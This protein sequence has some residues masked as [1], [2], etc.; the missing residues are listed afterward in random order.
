[1][2]VTRDKT[3]NS[4]AFLTVE[5]EPAEVEDA[6]K[7]AYRR[8]VKK[9]NIPGFRKGKAPRAILE[10]YLG[11]ESLLEDALNSLVP[12]AYQKAIKE[13]EIEA[14]AQPQIEIA[15]TDPVVFTAVVPLRPTVALGDH[16]KIKETPEAVAVGESDVDAVIEQLR[17]QHA[18]WEPVER[19]VELGDLLVVD[20]ESSIDDKPFVSQKEAQLQV[21]QDQVFPAP[22]F[23]ERLLGMRAGE[24]REFRLEFPPDYPRA[25]LVGKEAA[26]KVRVTEVKQERLPELSDE[27][28]QGVNPEF[29]TLDG[30]REQVSTSL[31][32]RAEEKAR[33]DF[34]ERVITAAV[35]LARLEFPPVLVEA[36]V[37]RLLN[38]QLQRWQMGGLDEYL[39]SVNKT[40]EELRDGLRPLATER[41]TRSLVLGKI[42]EEEKIEVSDA[43]IDAEVESM[44]KG[45]TEN[46]EQVGKWLDTPQ[47]REAIR[48]SLMARKTIQRLVETANPSRE[49]EAQMPPAGD[50]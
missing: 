33:I 9:A 43:E 40:E 8:L 28:A 4:Q 39:S 35:D 25:E 49:E 16:S 30:L 31:R 13:Q 48:Q 22:K 29:K 37:D 7:K 11:K 14:I 38:Q 18:T 41:V 47:T 5:L 15:Q 2:K 44:L 20:V 3:E 21:L 23:G 32:L 19:P 24:E 10:G 6:L 26:F 27:F 42:A 12:E 45:T 1:M 34:E 50:A 46:K 17:H 36:E